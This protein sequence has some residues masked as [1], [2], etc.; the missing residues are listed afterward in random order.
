VAANTI[1]L[2]ISSAGIVL[3]NTSSVPVDISG[4]S[5][6]NASGRVNTAAWLR[7]SSFNAARLSPRDC[8][9]AGTY[10]STPN[11]SACRYVLSSIQ[12]APE[13]AFWRQ[14]A[15]D[16]LN[17]DTLVATCRA[18]QTTCIIQWR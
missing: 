14:A 11:T 5:I 1:T 10:T 15:L 12:Y 3:Q 13:R 9:A 7:V 4:I 16:V 17:A 8:L 6:S 2:F 18:D